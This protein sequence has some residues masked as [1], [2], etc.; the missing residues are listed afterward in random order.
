MVLW[1][2]TRF[3]WIR[4]ISC[5]SQILYRTGIILTFRNGLKLLWDQC[6]FEIFQP[7]FGPCGYNLGWWME[8]FH[9]TLKTRI[10]PYLPQSLILGF[11]QSEWAI[12]SQIGRQ[13]TMP[14]QVSHLNSQESWPK[15]ASAS[16]VKGNSPRG[17]PRQCTDIYGGCQPISPPTWRIMPGLTQVINNHGTISPWDPLSRVV[18]PLPNGLLWLVNRKWG[19]LTTY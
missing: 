14:G 9:N 5:V 3:L 16:P 12:H 2:I 13:E 19:L 7:P 8:N 18:G 6:R 11:T 15:V 1:G 4:T 10:L 17:F